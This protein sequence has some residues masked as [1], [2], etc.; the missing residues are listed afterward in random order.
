VGY[1]GNERCD[2][3]QQEREKACGYSGNTETGNGSNHVYEPTAI[4]LA[5]V[6]LDDLAG[7]PTY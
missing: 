7:T 5:L 6:F 1:S 4:H 3:A 2:R